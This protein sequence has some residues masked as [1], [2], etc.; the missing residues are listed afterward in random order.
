MFQTNRKIPDKIFLASPI[1]MHFLDHGPRW[2][3]KT[4]RV[5]SS[6]WPIGRHLG[7]TSLL[8]HVKTGKP[9]SAAKSLTFGSLRGHFHAVRLGPIR[10]SD[11]SRAHTLENA[12]YIV[13][14]LLARGIFL[15]LIWLLSPRQGEFRLR[16]L[17]V[18]RIDGNTVGLYH[19][20]Q[21]TNK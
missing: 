14:A 9:T 11:P 3:L 20:N 17:E 19:A 8:H 16:K 1:N 5:L 6:P 2:W 7:T 18:P 12:Q 21:I 13:M 4:C 15:R 10:S